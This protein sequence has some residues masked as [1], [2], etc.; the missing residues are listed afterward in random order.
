MILCSKLKNGLFKIVTKS[1]VV[2]KFNVTKSRLHCI[3]LDAASMYFQVAFRGPWKLGLKNHDLYEMA[4]VHS[5]QCAIF[6]GTLYKIN[7]YILYKTII[8]TPVWTCFV[9]KNANIFGL[10]LSYFVLIYWFAF[11]SS[12]FR[13]NQTLKKN[14]SNN[15]AWLHH[16]L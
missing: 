6:F 10:I 13:N 11:I 7:K 16:R 8:G 5:S 4:A 2:T 3:A 15:Y 9:K 1:Q 12:P 14:W